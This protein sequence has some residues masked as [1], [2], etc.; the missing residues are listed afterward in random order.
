MFQ[1][2]TMW[3]HIRIQNVHPGLALPSHFKALSAWKLLIEHRNLSVSIHEVISLN[4]LF[5]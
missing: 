4:S 1:Y 3:S 2:F 5:L